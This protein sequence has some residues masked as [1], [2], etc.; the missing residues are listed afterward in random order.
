MVQTTCGPD[1]RAYLQYFKSKIG[2]KIPILFDVG[3]NRGD[4]TKEFLELFPDGTVY[5]FEPLP[6]I[7]G[8]SKKI[9]E[10][11]PNV[12]IENFGLG[13]I[14]ENATEYYLQ[15]GFDGMS[16]VFY[17]PKYFPKFNVK[18]EHIILKQFDLIAH[19]YPTPD[20]IKID[21]EGMDFYVLKGME[22]LLSTKRPP[23]I[24]IE[25]G[26]CLIDAQVTF[27]EIIDFLYEKR[28]HV[29]SREFIPVTPENV[30]E[31]YDCQNYLAIANEFS[32]DFS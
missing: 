16:S 1:E 15:D 9:F 27:K 24:Q 28:Y 13:H 10:S 14:S 21:T 11:N 20:F 31:N 22:N 23:L 19:N 6:E 5:G 2:N 29:I 12:I 18:I 26:E 17:R 8:L 7:Y 30:W 25:I 3:F 32:S 4:F